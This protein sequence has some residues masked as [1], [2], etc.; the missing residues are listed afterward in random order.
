[1]ANG[2]SVERWDGGGRRW[3][4]GGGECQLLN[5]HCCKNNTGNGYSTYPVAQ[6]TASL[7]PKQSMKMCVAALILFSLVGISQLRF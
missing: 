3:E 7:L 5:L 2:I 6:S 1:M 4:K